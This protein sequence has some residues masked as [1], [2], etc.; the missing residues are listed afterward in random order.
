[1]RGTGRKKPNNSSIQFPD[2]VTV[3]ALKHGSATLP[4]YIN[5]HDYHTISSMRWCA[6]RS[7]KT[8]YA[9]SATTGRIVRMHRLLTGGLADHKDRN[10]LN[11]RRSNLRQANTAQNNVNRAPS[12][13][14]RGITKIPSGWRAHISQNNKFVHLGVF[15][16]AV[17]AAQ[18]YDA[19]GKRLFGE[20]FIPNFPEVT[21][22]N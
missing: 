5:S 21:N 11:N 4:C 2:G 8:Y 6:K 3:L 12:T 14:L 18:A 17:L 19:A 1:M 10:G 16:T 20:F 13:S 15:P 22:V 9:V 7:R